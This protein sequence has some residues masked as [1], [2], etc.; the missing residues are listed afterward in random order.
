M[1]ADRLLGIKHRITESAIRAGRDPNKIKLLVVSKTQTMESVR[2][3]VRSGHVLFGENRVQEAA[4]KIAALDSAIQWHLIGHLQR[5]KA[6]QAVELFQMI[7]SVDSVPLAEELGRRSLSHGKIQDILV[8]VNISGEKSK[9]G[10]S[11]D[12]LFQLISTIRTLPGLAFKGL[13]TI[14]PFFD[15]PEDTRPFFQQLKSLADQIKTRQDMD[16]SVEMELSM[17]MSNDF[18]IAIE[19]GATIV[20]VGTAV[21]GSR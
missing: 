15:R 4:L 5:N 1:L 20:R 21:F 16:E 7:H 3:L 9:S 11:P 8:Q 17:G 12:R 2:E 19:E 13:M 10:I 18:E 6:K 14:P